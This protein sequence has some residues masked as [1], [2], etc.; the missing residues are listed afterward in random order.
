MKKT[1]NLWNKLHIMLACILLSVVL[2]P[3][4]STDMGIVK[5]DKP[6]VVVIDPGHGGENLGADYNGYVEKDINMVRLSEGRGT[7]VSKTGLG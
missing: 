5:A 7:E 3:L 6:C 1:I 4:S 2:L